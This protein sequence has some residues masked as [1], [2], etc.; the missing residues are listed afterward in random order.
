MTR[1]LNRRGLVAGVVGL[2]AVA[3]AWI[4]LA[5]Q[6]LGG[7][8]A[9]VTVTGSSMEPGLSSG[10]LAVV[11]RADGYGP[12]DAVAYRSDELRRVVLH[13][14]V[15]AQAGR[16]VLK[17]DAN[18]WVDSSRA[19]ESEV[20]GTLWIRIPWAGSALEWLRAPR[21]AALLGGLLALLTVAG[22]FGVGRRRRR[23]RRAASAGVRVPTIPNAELA[24]A[25]LGTAALAFGALAALAFSRPAERAVQRTVPYELHGR[26]SY[27]AKAPAGPVYEDGTVETGEPIFLRLVP[28]ATVSFSARLESEAPRSL[29]GTG[30]LVA[31]LSDSSG[32]TRTLE[33]QPATRFAGDSFTASGVLRLRAIRALLTDVATLTGVERDS[34][35][36]TLRPE[37][38]LRGTLAGRKVDDRFSPKLVFRLDAREL[39]LEP[40]IAPR[41]EPA[42]RGGVS[43]MTR[44]SQTFSLP[45]GLALGVGPARTFTLAGALGFLVAALAVA[46]LHARALRNDEPTRIRARYGAWLVPV[47]G[48]S[49]RVGGAVVDMATIEGLVRLAERSDRMILHEEHEGAHLYLLEDEGVL[50]RYRAGEVEPEPLGWNGP[51]PALGDEP[52]PAERVRGY[53]S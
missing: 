52:S 16:Y 35:G 45:G 29:S 28:A 48:A 15:R 50:Y 42:R 51:A 39:R 24:L 49:S 6:A 23:D 26:F 18:D 32:W 22:G 11:R 13:R 38:D 4:F 31:E 19:S 44:Q 10:D 46:F 25:L 20:L 5:P 7:P 30:K 47:A 40:A 34:Y 33:L 36:L 53:T 2:A 3:V 21:N 1:R 37:V 12:G 41:L 9:Y 8:L 27:S 43:T 14:I 17:G